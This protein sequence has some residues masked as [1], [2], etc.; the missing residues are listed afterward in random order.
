MYISKML[1]RDRELATLRGLL[2]RHPV[3]GIIGARQVGKTTLARTLMRAESQPTHRFDLEN[4][5]DLARLA[6]PMLALK[7]LRGLV[8]IDEIQRHPDLFNVLRVLA[9][10]PRHPC[11]FLVLGSAAPELLK[12]TA[13]TLAGRIAYHQLSRG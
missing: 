4:P 8:V 9:D 2:R 5:E 3:V 7:S 12:Q 13:E 1:Q 10:R 6:E 11:R